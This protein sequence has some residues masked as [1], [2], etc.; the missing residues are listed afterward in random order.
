MR[1]FQAHPN[2][3]PNTLR[4]VQ[5]CSYSGICLPSAFP[6]EKIVLGSLTGDRLGS[7]V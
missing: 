4:G 6:I 2:H 3:G 7:L 5:T 1:T